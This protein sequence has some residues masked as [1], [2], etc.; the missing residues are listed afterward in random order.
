MFGSAVVPKLGAGTRWIL[1]MRLDNELEY[2][3]PLCVATITESVSISPQ[4]DD[5]KPIVDALRATKTSVPSVVLVTLCG[6]AT[7]GL[8]LLWSLWRAYCVF[9]DSDSFYSRAIEAAKTYH[10]KRRMNSASGNFL[11]HPFAQ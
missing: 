10:C 5:A 4:S 9:S 11:F 1:G 7:F 6:A 3:S 2:F 8:Y